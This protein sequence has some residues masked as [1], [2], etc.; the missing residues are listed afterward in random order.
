M[1]NQNDTQLQEELLEKQ[2]DEIVD[3][4]IQTVRGIRQAV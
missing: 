1:N 3:S 2:K 4:T